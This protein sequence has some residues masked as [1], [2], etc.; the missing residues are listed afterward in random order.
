MNTLNNA[1]DSR[2]Y[3]WKL[4]KVKDERWGGWWFY[5]SCSC[6][7]WTTRTKPVGIIHCPQCGKHLEDYINGSN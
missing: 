4:T 3:K 5:Y 6:C 1:D 2:P 7:G